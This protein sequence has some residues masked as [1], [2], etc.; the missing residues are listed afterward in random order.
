MINSLVNQ[1]ESCFQD[2]LESTCRELKKGNLSPFQIVPYPQITLNTILKSQLGDLNKA[3]HDLEKRRFAFSCASVDFLLV[4]NNGHRIPLVA[5]ERQGKYHDESSRQQECDQMKLELLNQAGILL[6]WQK[7]PR[8]GIIELY[9][10]LQ[11]LL[12]RFNVYSG[13]GKKDF[14]YLVETCLLNS[15]KKIGL[16]DMPNYCDNNLF[17]FPQIVK[18]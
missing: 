5:I 13:D 6:L 12:C 3:I 8:M 9:E 14:I 1:G 18:F 2:L 4:L 15:I 16:D 7:E 11:R 10:P 17:E